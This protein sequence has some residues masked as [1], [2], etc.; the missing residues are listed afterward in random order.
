MWTRV[1]SYL[2]N[3]RLAPLRVRS[4]LAVGLVLVLFVGIGVWYSLVV[5]PF[6]T[7]DE[8]Y[9]YA[10]VRHLAEGGG[11]PVQSTDGDGPWAHEGTQA[12]LYYFLAGRLTAGI[13]QSDLDQLTRLN[14][15]ANLGNPFALGNKNL[16][17]YS[18]HQ[19]SLQGSNLALHVDRW[20][21]LALMAGS[22]WL[23]YRIARL[24]FPHSTGWPI[25]AMLVVASIPQFA[26][27][28]ASA[29]NDSMMI[30]TSTASVYWLARL[31]VLPAERPVHRWEWLVL[32]ILLGLAALSKLQGLGLFALAALA[33]TWMA[34]QRRT[35]RLLAEAGT[36]V[37]LPA[38][39]IAGWWYWRNFNLYR[40][41][42]GAG[43][44][45]RI[46][47]QRTRPLTWRGLWGEM[48]GLR[49]SFWGLFG[50][51]SIPLPAWIYRLLDMFTGLALVGVLASVFVHRPRRAGALLKSPSVRVK[52]LL[53]A[54]AVILGGL[55]LYWATFATSSQGRLLFPAISSFGVL[56]VA[57]LAS[58]LAFAVK[59]VKPMSL[60]WLPCGLLICSAYALTTLLPDSYHAPSPVSTVSAQ[61]TV[62]NRHYD[63]GLQIVGIDIPGGHYRPGD[64]VP[65][66]LYLRTT[67]P[68]TEDVPLFVQLLNEDGDVIGN[69]T[70]NAGWGRNPTS[71]W[72]PGTIY[73]DPYLVTIQGNVSGHSP[74]LARV[75]VGFMQADTRMPLDTASPDGQPVPE[76]VGNV[77]I[78]PSMPLDV[79]RLGLKPLEVSFADG[80][81]LLGYSY[82]PAVQAGDGTLPVKLLWQA[83]GG[84]TNDYSAFVHLV[85]ANGR[86]AGGFDT[87]PAEGKYPTSAWQPNDRSLSELPIALPADL[88]P[89]T[90]K[91]WVGLYNA[92]DA[93]MP[94]LAVTSSG[95]TVQDQS[96]LLG[97]V[98]VRW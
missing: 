47:G 64:G 86:P 12:P 96:I 8:L 26:F 74:E 56:M 53:A 36:L 70:S 92:N 9:H 79:Q 30:F 5:P 93:A 16:M 1:L 37:L 34:W 6:E 3:N 87:P 27:I 82:P 55:M 25:L 15:Y 65:L 7:P 35:W 19:W 80:M 20:F 48:R 88:L 97:T 24:A 89:G 33:I 45:L 84:P 83:D 81:Q 23:T 4:R 61:T 49:Y 38:V 22:L 75:Y 10:F 90:Y 43:P 41:W 71:L 40:D 21:S 14:P 28:G 32:G 85:N 66:T 60:V 59:S 72:I 39:A 95:S 54:W 29:S 76:F 31:I 18:A 46:N 98:E 77:R 91:L 42:L 67:R 51:F 13:D 57:G 17:L 69:V 58:W 94:R 62:L 63:N 11:L 44:L 78:E 73:R 68:F 52:L 2:T 50:W